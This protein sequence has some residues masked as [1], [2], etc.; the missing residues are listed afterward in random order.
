MHCVSSFLCLLWLAN[1]VL[2]FLLALWF[3]PQST[4]LCSRIRRKL[5]IPNCVWGVLQS[6]QSGFVIEFL[7]MD[8]LPEHHWVANEFVLD[9]VDGLFDFSRILQN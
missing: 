4:G 6:S 8:M 1:F 7:L 9:A 3:C 5:T 2:V